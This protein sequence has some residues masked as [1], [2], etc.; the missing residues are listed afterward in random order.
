[1]EPQLSAT[2]YT[3]FYRELLHVAYGGESTV[4][5]FLSKSPKW[6][7]N[8]TAIGNYMANTNGI[9]DSVNKYMRD[10]AVL[11]TNDSLKADQILGSDDGSKMVLHSAFALDGPHMGNAYMS[12]QFA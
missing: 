11:N 7:G 3:F 4:K 12:Y 9:R 10:K 1:M 2:G 8:N 6:T 5:D